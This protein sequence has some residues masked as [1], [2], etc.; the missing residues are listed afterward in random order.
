[1]TE[2]LK[3]P[4]AT[5]AT[6]AAGGDIW[7]GQPNKVEPLAGRIE[8]GYPPNEAPPAS[9]HNWIFSQ[10]SKW[11]DRLATMSLVFTQARFASVAA[12]SWG[13]PMSM[14]YCDAD[15]SFWGIDQDGLT[16]FSYNQ[17]IAVT[18]AGGE[19]TAWNDEDT[20]GGGS[21]GGGGAG[22]G[23]TWV[24]TGTLVDI[25]GSPFYAAPNVKWLA[26]SNSAA[27][28]ISG[29]IV[30]GTW[31]AEAPASAG[32]NW[33]ACV[34]DRTGEWII[35]SHDGIIENAPGLAVPG[36]LAFVARFN[37]PS[38]TAILRLGAARSASNPSDVD[39]ISI[40][41][42]GAG[43]VLIG[44]SSDNG[45][46]WAS[47]DSGWVETPYDIA[48]NEETGRWVIVSDGV[49]LP[50]E[51]EIHYSDSPQTDVWTTVTT[52]FTGGDFGAI[53][54][55]HARLACFRGMWIC[56]ASNQ[57]GA[58]NGIWVSLDDAETWAPV[59]ND[60][61]VYCAEACLAAGAYGFATVGDTGAL[62]SAPIIVP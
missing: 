26:V 16:V 19:G 54:V 5:D 30:R 25:D 20:V 47:W 21:P 55:T 44:Y 37:S 2:P 11:I 10:L 32:K 41:E 7:S 51:G 28:Q 22:P 62:Y 59:F 61:A 48:V 58:K 60:I 50:G 34:C 18:T 29:S 35:G 31:V 45:D 53:G 56:L 43:N 33:G 1:M 13:V 23:G 38:A 12:G 27:T 57:G 36:A 52:P 39:V 9:E 8:E 4:W 3:F 42:T 15:R 46:N 40:Q 17:G 24:V 49:A 14:G 6:Y